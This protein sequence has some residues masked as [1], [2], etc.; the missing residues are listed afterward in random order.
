MCQ[1]VGVSKLMVMRYDE[2]KPVAQGRDGKKP[3]AWVI[4][5]HYPMMTEC[6]R[7]PRGRRLRVI[8]QSVLCPLLSGKPC[9]VLLCKNSIGHVAYVRS[10]VCEILSIW[11]WF[12]WK[13]FAKLISKDSTHDKKGNKF[14]IESIRITSLCGFALTLIKWGNFR[15]NIAMVMMMMMMIIIIFIVHN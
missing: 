4:L 1:Q 9:V 7:V 3:V 14:S 5:P 11:M 8:E 6:M 10:G 13:W 2:G 12:V 15:I